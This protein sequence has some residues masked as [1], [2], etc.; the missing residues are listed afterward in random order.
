MV[1]VNFTT[2]DS[3]I[4]Y[5]YIHI[6][7]IKYN[8]CVYISNYT[9]NVYVHMYMKPPVANCIAGSTPSQLYVTQ[10]ERISGNRLRSLLN[11]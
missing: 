4:L 6:V 1:L 10:P 3:A 8:M 7:Y 5:K 2:P 11:T 9:F